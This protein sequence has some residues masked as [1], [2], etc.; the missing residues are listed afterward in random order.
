MAHALL[1]AAVMR[2]TSLLL[3]SVVAVS[4]SGCHTGS[5]IA[6]QI[7]RTTDG[8]VAI[9]A[10][11]NPH[12]DGWAE[13]WTDD[14]T[15]ILLL[16]RSGA[17]LTDDAPSPAPIVHSCSAVAPPCVGTTLGQGSANDPD[18]RW[19]LPDGDI[20]RNPTGSPRI[21]RLHGDTV[22]WSTV[23]FADTYVLPQVLFDDTLYVEGLGDRKQL[24]SLDV[25]T[26]AVRW[27]LDLTELGVH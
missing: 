3:L 11:L 26:G 9:T 4:L 16:S 8:G 12:Y 19:R 7:E 5:W 15:R 22:L 18:Y 13:H 27:S 20:V 10:A 21:E 14:G 2:T 6:Q 24:A 25:T 23:L 17:L 1:N